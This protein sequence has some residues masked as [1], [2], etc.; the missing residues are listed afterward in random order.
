MED[1]HALDLAGL[2]TYVRERWPVAVGRA[3]DKTKA[4]T[5]NSSTNQLI[6]ASQRASSA[7]QRVV[8]LHR[9]ASAW[10]TP[11][12][13]V[14]ACSQGCSHCCNT[15]VT[16][17]SLEADLI[18][19]RTGSKPAKPAHAVRLQD[20]PDLDQAI[21]ALQALTAQWQG[22]PCPLLQDGA[23]SV[24][25]VRPMACRLLINLDDDDLLCRLVPGQAI[26]VPYANSQKLKAMFLLA[27]PA[28]PLADIRDFYPDEPQGS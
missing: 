1:P 12:Q 23:C 3:I 14:A 28:A 22:V 11:L 26:P 13:A 10:S 9:A 6:K 16:I 25:D 15:P 8:W 20:F 17:S 18:D 24:Y 7:S 27:Q 2:P 4:L 21:P 5:P 19:R